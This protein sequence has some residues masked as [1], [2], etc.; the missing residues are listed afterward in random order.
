V[1]QAQATG[2]RTG[3]D[4]KVLVAEY[5]GKAFPAKVTR[6][7][8]AIDPVSRTLAMELELPNGDQTLLP[9]MFGRV[10][11]AARGCEGTWTVPAVALLSKSGG[12]HVA[13][14]DDRSVVRLRKVRI[15]RDYG[16]RVE[17]LDGLRG[18][19]ALVANPPDDLADNEA[20]TIAGPAAALAAQ[21]GPAPDTHAP[22]TP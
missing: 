12:L 5:P 8:H 21:G 9:G 2:I 16:D 11:L 10:E 19:E 14:V 1:P 13:V 22:K 18:T 20:V 15:G 6:T 7:A 4:A 3:Q 17:V